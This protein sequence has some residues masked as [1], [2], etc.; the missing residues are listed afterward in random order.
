M[1][2]Y[3]YQYTRYSS[4]GVLIGYAQ[5]FRTYCAGARGPHVVLLHGGGY[6]SM[7][8]CLTTVCRAVCA[9]WYCSFVPEWSLFCRLQAMLKDYFTI[10]TIDFRAHGRDGDSTSLS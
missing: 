6:S 1:E 4:G 5:V 10:H 8:W 9:D 2:T 7:T 3:V